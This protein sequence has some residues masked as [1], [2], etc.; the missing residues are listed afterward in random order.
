MPPRIGFSRVD[1]DVLRGLQAGEEEHTSERE[2]R[3][4][5]ERG[6]WRALVE[7]RR[8]PCLDAAPAFHEA[9]AAARSSKSL[10]SRAFCVSEAARSNSARA[11]ALRPSFLQEIAAH[12]RQQV[13]V[14]Q[15]RFGGQ[16]I[17][18]LKPGLRA[19]RHR[20]RDR[21][22][23]LDHR[24]RRA[25]RKL[26]IK[27][28][29]ARPVRFIRRTR[30]RMTGR[31][32][33]LQHI[34][35]ALRAEPLGTL[36]RAEPAADQ[37]VVPAGA[38]LLEQQDRR[39][40]RGGACTEPRSLDFHQRD[41]PMHLRLGGRQLGKNAPQPQR[42]LAQRGPDPVLAGRCRIAFVEDQV[43]HF[44]HRGEPLAE[45][46]AARHF[47]RHARLGQRALGA[48]DALRD[49]RLR[50]QEGARD[51]LGGEPAD[52][53]QRQRDARLGREHRMAG[54]EDQ[55]QQIVADVVVERRVEIGR[56]RIVHLAADLLVL[57]LDQ[58]GA[59]VLV[60]RAVLRGRHQPG[61]GIVGNASFRPA[62]ERGDQRILR[63]LF[64]D[65][66]VARD[67]RNAGDDL[68]LLDA[69]DRLDRLVRVGSHGSRLEQLAC[70]SQARLRAALRPPT[71]AAAPGLRSPGPPSFRE[72]RSLG[73]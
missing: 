16:R 52:Q 59:A 12:A 22:V 64:G 71:L 49:G 58:L 5:G 54:G 23:E 4:R 73:R 57:A 70:V 29:D 67:A 19:H 35:S 38:V 8:E 56:V 11:S 66:D 53:P 28:G 40:V 50:H 27:R 51:L 25:P 2:Q 34:G 14:L 17:D 72:A 3:N 46:R 6:T 31:D 7:L 60:E 63:Q 42:L 61:G 21:A 37:E 13:I 33:G 44:Q 20:D 1:E 62:L 15:R 18:Q 39:A 24:R 9:S 32:R 68:R 43:D 41:E 47:V 26:P 65:A 69:P 48:H 36:E 30:P 10:R 45:R 55:P